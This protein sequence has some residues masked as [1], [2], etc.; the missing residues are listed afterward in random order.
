MSCQAMQCNDQM[1]CGK[2]GLQWDVNDPEP[3]GCDPN[4]AIGKRTFKELKVLLHET[5]TATNGIPVGQYRV[6]I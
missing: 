2:C 1:I 4:R 6:H 5:N 3:P